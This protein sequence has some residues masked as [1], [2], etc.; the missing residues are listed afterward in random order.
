MKNI[1]VVVVAALAACGHSTV[2]TPA[3]EPRPM[4]TFRTTGFFVRDVPATVQFYEAAFGLHMRYM[5][6]SRGYAELDTGAT[7]LA[8][9][10]EAFQADAALLGGR[11]IRFNR[12]ELDPIAAHVAFVTS[13][14]DADWRRAVDAGAEIVKLP[15][16]KPWGQTTG[17]LRDP[18]G[19]IVELCTKSPRDP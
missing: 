8:F 18:N 15:E 6:P 13:D 11:T 1:A 14:L 16:R 12:R 5:H 17:Y 4:L 10:S 7:L 9:V 2:V 3:Q 19:V